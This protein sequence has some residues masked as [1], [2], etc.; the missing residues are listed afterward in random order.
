M[1]DK[2]NATVKDFSSSFSHLAHTPTRILAVRS[3]IFHQ[4]LCECESVVP[5]KLYGVLLMFE[6]FFSLFIF[7]SAYFLHVYFKCPK[8]AA[9]FIKSFQMWTQY[10]RSFG[11]GICCYHTPA[12]LQLRTN[13]WK[14]CRLVSSYQEKMGEHLYLVYF[15]WFVRLN[16]MYNIISICT[17]HMYEWSSETQWYENYGEHH[18]NCHKKWNLYHC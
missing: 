8:N 6:M 17:E 7:K 12:Y 15:Q 4:E 2:T 5:P 18:S 14:N 9:C 1:L 16:D 3:A 10:T 13:C 11:I